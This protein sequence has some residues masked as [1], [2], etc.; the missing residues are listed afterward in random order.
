[1]NRRKFL[2]GAGSLAAGSAAAMGTGAFSSTA[3]G[4][5]VSV[6]VAGDQ[7]AYLSIVPGDSPHAY[8]E[9]GELVLDFDGSEVSGEGLNTNAFI[10]FND[11]FEIQNNSGNKIALWLDDGA[12]NAPDVNNGYDADFIQQLSGTKLNQ[13]WRFF[14]SFAREDQPAAYDPNGSDDL[15]NEFEYGLD[16]NGVLAPTNVSA[17]PQGIFNRAGKHPAVLESGDNLSINFQ[18]NTKASADGNP[19]APDPSEITDVGGEIVLN[20]YSKEFAQDLQS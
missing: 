7:N 19:Q 8:T 14:W 13:D 11:L 5:S 15:G 17:G 4:R 3:A 10:K 2:I 9:G 18:I 1:M 12:K 6:S 20:G 16:D